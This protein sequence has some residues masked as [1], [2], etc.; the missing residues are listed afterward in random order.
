MLLSYRLL[1]FP[2]VMGPKP[3]GLTVSCFEVKR[4]DMLV[5]VVEGGTVEAVNE[6]SIRSEVEGTAR[7]IFIVPEGSNAKEGDLLVQ[8]DSSSSENQVN[9][10]QIN[11]EKAQ[12]ALVQAE[13][14]LE[15]QKS[16]VDSEIAAAKM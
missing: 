1:R 3:Q 2:F 6:I 5:S 12:F 15:I 16:V 7:I 4:S 9:L 8:L 10:Q 13:Q 14:Q 11:V